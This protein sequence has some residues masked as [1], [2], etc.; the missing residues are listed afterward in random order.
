MEARNIFMLN[1]D[2]LIGFFNLLFS[3]I[4]IVFFLND[5]I[6]GLFNVNH[7]IYCTALIITLANV[8]LITV[9]YVYFF[10]KYIEKKEQQND[11]NCRECLRNFFIAQNRFFENS[12]EETIKNISIEDISKMMS[13]MN[14]ISS[15][16]NNA[17]SLNS[18]EIEKINVLL[19]ALLQVKNGTPSSYINLND[20]S[21][22]EASVHKNSTIEIVSSSLN[23]DKKLQNIIIQNLKN[24]VKYNYYLSSKDMES[25]L[26]RFKKNIDEWK[27]AVGEKVIYNQVKC[28]TFPYEIMQMTLMI[29]ESNKYVEDAVSK[30][31]IVVKFP[32][33]D[34]SVLEHY[35][36]FF[37]INNTPALS[38]LFYEKFTAIKN[39]PKCKNHKISEIELREK[40]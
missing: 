27:K 37:Y 11:D 12:L 25:L 34:E 19:H 26:N 24:G 5:K 21:I 3:I 14:A 7:D 28:Y 32:Y 23:C 1:K 17:T 15:N 9:V 18:N 39:N 8:I 10:K 31:S 35:P 4:I 36:L 2:K 6:S 16:P 29:Y 22:I 13:F 38:D 33:I 30:P 40:K 20:I